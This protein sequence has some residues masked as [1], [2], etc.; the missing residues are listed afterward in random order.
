MEAALKLDPGVD[1]E[2][3]QAVAAAHQSEDGIG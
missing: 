2:P 3:A 1:G